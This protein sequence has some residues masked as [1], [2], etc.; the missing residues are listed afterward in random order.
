MRDIGLIGFGAIGGAIIDLWPSQL[1]GRERLTA[2][3][4]RPRQFAAARKAVGADIAV[5]SGLTEFLDAAPQLVIEAA[6]QAAVFEYGEAV[7]KAGCELHLLSAGALADGCLHTRLCAA[8]KTGDGR[9]AIPA[10]ALAGFDGLASLRAAGLTSVRYSSTKP[11]AAWRGTPAEDVADLDQL[12][13]PK[14]VFSGDARTAARKFPRNAN[15]AA[16]VA[17]AGIGFD[18]TEVELIADPNAV[19][20]SGR[21]QAVADAGVL[22]V[23]MTSHGFD[24]NRKSSRI[25]AMSVIAALRARTEPI[26]FA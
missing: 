15:L 12:D 1:A 19:A 9:L 2:I 14:V 22:D 4:V 3:L 24:G 16:A 11:P 23:T 20:N 21:I 7:L 18:R 26:V 8:A 25:T 17:L 13:G 5:T 10:G 6:G